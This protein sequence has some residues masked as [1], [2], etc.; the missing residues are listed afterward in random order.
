MKKARGRL[1]VLDEVV[2][3]KEGQVYLHRNA[4]DLRTEKGM[5]IDSY[6]REVFK[7]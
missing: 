4:D 6:F 1:K 5:S 3:L 7:C 2:F